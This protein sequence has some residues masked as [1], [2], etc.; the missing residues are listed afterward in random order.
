MG[1]IIPWILAGDAAVRWCSMTTVAAGA[2]GL[3]VAR[4]NLR[5]W[6]LRR[7]L[8]SECGNLDGL[9]SFHSRGLPQ[10]VGDSAV[11]L[12]CHGVRVP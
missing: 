12:G 3:G 2:F 4:V 10:H 6:L 8:Q 7:S 9:V 1:D 11:M 5:V